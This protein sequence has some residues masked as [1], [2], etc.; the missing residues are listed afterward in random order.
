MFL[1]GPHFPIGNSDREGNLEHIPRSLVHK[2]D[3]T[4]LSYFFCSENVVFFQFECINS[5]NN[6]YHN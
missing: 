1:E 4:T 3:V 2:T 5:F 6:L